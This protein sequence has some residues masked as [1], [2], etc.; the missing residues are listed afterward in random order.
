MAL[1]PFRFRIPTY[2]VEQISRKVSSRVASQEIIGARPTTHLLGPGEETVKF[3]STFY[4]FHLN[5]GGLQQL[6]GIRGSCLDQV[7]LMLISVAGLVYGRWIILDVSDERTQ[8]SRSGYPQMV[9]V[10]M[11][12]KRYVPR[13]GGSGF[14]I[15]LF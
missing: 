12:L 5:G 8:I 6:E 4:P 1:G 7:P 2:S 10:D 14:S 11:N 3:S 9:T 13:G 15:G